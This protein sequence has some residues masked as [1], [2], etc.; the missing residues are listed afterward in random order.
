MKQVSYAALRYLSAI[1]YRQLK[2]NLDVSEQVVRWVFMT[3]AIHKR[4]IGIHG[5]QLFLMDA[6][7]TGIM[8]NE[9]GVLFVIY[10]LYF[11]SRFDA[12]ACRLEFRT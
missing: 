11:P 5:N 3:F 7:E 4:R 12:C 9:I 10:S 6:R 2:I 1:H 8:W